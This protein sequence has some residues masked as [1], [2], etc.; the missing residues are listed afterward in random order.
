MVTRGGKWAVK[1]EGETRYS[2]QKIQ[3]FTYK[4]NKYKG[5]KVQHDKYNQ[6]AI[7]YI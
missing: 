2:C 4:I 3:T 7:Y 1:R 6:D 5:Y